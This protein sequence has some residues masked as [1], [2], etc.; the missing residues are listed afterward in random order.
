MLT[1]LLWKEVTYST[2]DVVA[3]DTDILILLIH[4]WDNS[5]NAFYFNTE[6]RQKSIKVNK[7]WNIEC[8]KEGS[9]SD[10]MDVILFA[11]AWGGCDTTSAIYCKG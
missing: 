4:H 7:W 1:P 5:K 6:K 9:A 8:F 3:K 10:W 2:V 11:H